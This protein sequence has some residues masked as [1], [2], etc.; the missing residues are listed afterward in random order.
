MKVATGASRQ[1]QGWECG[2]QIGVNFREVISDQDGSDSTSL[3]QGDSHLQLEHMD[4]YYDKATG[5]KYVPRAVLVDQ[6]P[7]SMD[8]VHLGPFGQIFRPDNLVFG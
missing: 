1:P 7:G 2:R 8:L 4:V 5:D 6:E 3:C